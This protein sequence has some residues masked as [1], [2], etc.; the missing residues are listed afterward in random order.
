MANPCTDKR[1]SPKTTLRAQSLFSSFCLENSLNRLR[2][3]LSIRAI[4]IIRLIRGHL[5]ALPAP[6]PVHALK[7]LTLEKPLRP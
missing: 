7:S 4:S 5:F 3:A 2:F 6:A 1:L